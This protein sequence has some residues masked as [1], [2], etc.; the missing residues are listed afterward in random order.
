MFA[1]SLFTR[2]GFDSGALT[3]LATIAHPIAE[4]GMYRITVIRDDEEVVDHIVSVD[5]T[6]TAAQLDVDLAALA[7]GG[8]ARLARPATTGG[9]C[10]GGIAPGTLRPGGYLQFLV[11]SGDREYA[12]VVHRVDRIDGERTEE[13]D[14]RRLMPG[15]VV[16]AVLLR[17][18]LYTVEDVGAGGKARVH[19][20]YPER[21]ER[22][23]PSPPLTIDLAA[24]PRVVEADPAQ[25]LLL[26][27]DK[28]S[29][30]VVTLE[31]PEELSEPRGSA[32]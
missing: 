4:P 24:K 15:D 20:R 14:T 2:T 26:N 21:G 22:L 17:P 11:G 1:T 19:V 31:K 16:A 27:A 23:H 12:A 9:C 6:S 7:P 30:F 18:G 3:R 13:F 29:R 8:A 32:S 28:G 25:G 5:D 10:G